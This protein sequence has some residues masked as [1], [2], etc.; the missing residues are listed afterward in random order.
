MGAPDPSMDVPLY[1]VGLAVFA[2]LY[3]AVTAFL[4]WAILITLLVMFIFLTLR[5]GNV[6]ENYPHSAQDVSI[7]AIFI[8]MTWGIFVFA[9]PKDPVPLVGQG[10]TYGTGVVPV[11]DIIAISVVMLVGF[12][13][14]YSFASEKLA[15]SRKAMGGA[16]TDEAGGKP[17]QGVGA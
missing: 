4:L 7:T 12:L 6:S 5:Y 16:S 11:S 13:I 3:I 15:E 14:V 2:L 10:F 8:G 17:K 1:A 9:G